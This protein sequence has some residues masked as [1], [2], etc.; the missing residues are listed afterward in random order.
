MKIEELVKE[1][2]P[3]EQLVYNKSLSW[4]AVTT[5]TEEQ[6]KTRRVFKIKDGELEEV[7]FKEVRKKLIE[8]IMEKI[9]NDKLV[10]LVLT[11]S[12]DTTLPQE[13]FDLI[14]R[15]LEN[16]G[17]VKQSKGCVELDISGKKGRH[18]HYRIM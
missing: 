16:K 10:A 17:E 11:E 7:P 12:I 5:T 2:K 18:M 13:L 1:L 4:V 3:G 8:T 14:E 6:Q 15:V 9:D